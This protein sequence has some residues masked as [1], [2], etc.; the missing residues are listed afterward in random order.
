MNTIRQYLLIGLGALVGVLMIVVKILAGRNSRL[1]A[2]LETADAR[3]HHAKVVE[4]QKTENAEVFKSRRAEA[5]AE[6]K[7]AGV[8]KE[9]EN[10]NDW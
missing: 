6:I 7:K 3:I 8:S 2:K 10:P 9:L 5:K 4:Q 1:S